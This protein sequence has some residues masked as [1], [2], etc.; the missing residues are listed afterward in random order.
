METPAGQI[1]PVLQT[2]RAKR[3][4]SSSLPPARLA[5]LRSLG[6]P[7]HGHSTPPGPWRADFPEVSPRFEK[8]CRAPLRPHRIAAPAI[9]PPVLSAGPRSGTHVPVPSVFALT[10][11]AAARRG[12]RTSV[13]KVRLHRASGM[14]VPGRNPQKH[15][16]ALGR[17]FSASAHQLRGSG[18][19]QRLRFQITH[20]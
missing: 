17:A 6:R 5:S 18:R 8:R 20:S 1:L 4:S 12:R 14:E 15:R 9:A 2:L 10:A 11:F 16:L 3:A 19:V 7:P 13:S